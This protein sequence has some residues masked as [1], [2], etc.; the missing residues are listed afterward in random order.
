MKF[1]AIF[2]F[3]L[4]TSSFVFSEENYIVVIIDD[5]AYTNRQIKDFALRKNLKTD[6]PKIIK[7][8]I[9]YQIKLIEAEKLKLKPSR[10]LIENNLKI[11]ATKNNITLKELTNFVDFEKVYR[12]VENDLSVL[13]LKN[14]VS[15]N[16]SNYE[17]NLIESN[18]SED[19]FSRWIN[20]AKEKYFIKSLN[21]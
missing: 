21:Y 16:R 6:K 5:S 11:I 7:D 9:D 14:H 17:N 13:L 4:L 1:K 19:F 15:K 3:I 8:F 18:S 10:P 12:D 20:S 2:L